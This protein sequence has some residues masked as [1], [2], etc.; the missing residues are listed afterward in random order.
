[1]HAGSLVWT[2]W[3]MIFVFIG[4]VFFWGFRLRKLA[5]ESMAGAFLADRKIPGFIGSLS[6]VAT[7][8]NIND[9]IGGAGMVYAFGAIWAHT[10]IISGLVLLFVSV[11]LVQKPRRKGR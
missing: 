2:E 9:F 5:S 11:F 4:G 8:L 3:L 6:T 10:Y 1:M 7:N